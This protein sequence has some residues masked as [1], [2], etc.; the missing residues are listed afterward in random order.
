MGGP[1]Y[2]STCIGTFVAE[3]VFDQRDKKWP[4]VISDQHEP[5]TG[6]QPRRGWGIILELGELL[7]GGVAV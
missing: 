1:G 4:T 2:R 7:R 5:L 3:G 6:T